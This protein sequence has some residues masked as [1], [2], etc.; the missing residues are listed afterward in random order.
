MV[1]ELSYSKVERY[2]SKIIIKNLIYW[3]LE[4]LSWIFQ[5]SRFI[6]ATFNR[7]SIAN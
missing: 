1:L 4:K 5:I 2:K 3:I 6:D 7:D